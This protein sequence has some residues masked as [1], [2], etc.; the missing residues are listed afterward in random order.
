MPFAVAY[1][2]ARRRKMK[3]GFTLIELL[4]VVLII[5]ILSAVALPQYTKAITKTRLANLKALVRS[6][7]Q[8]AEVYYMA[9]GKYPSSLDELDVKVGGELL[10]SGQYG[11]DWGMCFLYEGQYGN[12]MGCRNNKSKV[13]YMVYFEKTNH[14]KKGQ[15]VCFS[16]SPDTNAA[17]YYVCKA[18]TNNA[19]PSWHEDSGGY[20]IFTYP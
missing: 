11:F 15:A 8:S 10:A 2:P 7:A 5:G 12:R 6:V 9:N 18:E 16:M 19:T 3:K 13:G 17:A 1:R 20:Y 4:V 14:S